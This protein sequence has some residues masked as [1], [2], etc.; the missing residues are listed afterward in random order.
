MQISKIRNRESR[1]GFSLIEAMAA[2]TLLAFIG[3]SVWIIINRCMTAAADCVQQMRAF[4]T[5]RENMEGLLTSEAVEAKTD[6]G[7]SDKY[8]D[9]QWRTTV[10][11]VSA[12][13]GSGMWAQAICSAEYTDAAGEVRTVELTHWL[14][15]LTKE[16]VDKMRAMTDQQQAE[17]DEYIIETAQQAAAYIGVTSETIEQ[18]VDG[19]MPVTAEG[20]YLKP[21]LELYF[22][23]KGQPNPMERAGVLEQHPGLK[24]AADGMQPGGKKGAQGGQQPAQQGNSD[25]PA[26]L[27]KIMPP[28]M[29]ELLQKGK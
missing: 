27:Q 9:I 22:E 10:E 24:A 8:P 17:L 6:F 15:E 28:E 12:P 26:D 1:G 4:E 16:Q 19:G 20:Y 3:G 13:I 11:T 5:A 23:T 14:T 2:V 18:W 25:I 21:W 29:V 7:F